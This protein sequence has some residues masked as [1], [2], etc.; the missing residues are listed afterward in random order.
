MLAVGEVEQHP[1]NPFWGS[2]SEEE[3]RKGDIGVGEKRSL[4]AQAFLA[5]WAGA[6]VSSWS[7]REQGQCSFGLGEQGGVASAWGGGNR[8]S[9]YT[10]ETGGPEGDGVSPESVGAGKR[11]MGEFPVEAVL[12]G[13]AA[14]GGKGRGS[15]G[16]EDILEG[17]GVGRVAAEALQQ[18]CNGRKSGAVRRVR[19]R[20]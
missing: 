9:P 4:L 3:G 13:E 10:G 15:S 11:G 12:R 18:H 2:G 8:R 1:G 6:A 7:G 14:R 19:I 16:Q 5:G 17:G 20:S